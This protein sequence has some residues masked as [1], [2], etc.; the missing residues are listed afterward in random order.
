[1][2]KATSMV[3]CSTGVPER[4][5]Q[6]ML[7][8]LARVLQAGS[9][10]PSGSAIVGATVMA[11]DQDRGTEWPTTTNEDGIYTFP[12]IPVGTYSLKVEAR[13]SRPRSTR[14]RAGSQSA[15]ARRRRPAGRRRHRNREGLRRRR[16]AANRNHPGRRVISRKPSTTPRSSAAT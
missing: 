3:S 8:R 11:K 9:R 10:D 14:P 7:R 16:D 1:M 5:G 6:P 2:R 15:W 12:R 4:M 13:G